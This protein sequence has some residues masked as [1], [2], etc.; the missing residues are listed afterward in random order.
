MVSAFEEW[1]FSE[2]ADGIVPHQYIDSLLM[3]LRTIF[4]TT[5]FSL[6]LSHNDLKQRIIKYFSLLHQIVYNNLQKKIEGPYFLAKAP[7]DWTERDEYEWQDAYNFHF[8]TLFWERLLG[9]EKA[10]EHRVIKW[11][12]ALPSILMCYTVRSYDNLPHLEDDI[13][14][15]GDYESFTEVD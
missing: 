8:D 4:K 15:D 2:D 3:N 9:S 6:A 1:W 12:Y 14:S 11:R 5:K 7:R 10:W 13:N